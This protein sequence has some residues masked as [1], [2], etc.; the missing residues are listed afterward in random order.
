MS[1]ETIVYVLVHSSG[2]T[3]TTVEHYVF[4]GNHVLS[5]KARTSGVECARQ[6]HQYW[7][8]PGKHINTEVHCLGR[9]WSIVYINKEIRYLFQNFYTFILK[10]H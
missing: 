5:A 3:K 2:E 6:A 4:S 1:K 8:T 9:F 10:E 7:G